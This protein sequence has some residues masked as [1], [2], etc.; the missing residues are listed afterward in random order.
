MKNEV[1]IAIPLSTDVIHSLTD[2]RAEYGLDPKRQNMGKGTFTVFFSIDGLGDDK[3]FVRLQQGGH[4]KVEAIVHDNEGPGLTPQLCI[5][6]GQWH[7]LEFDGMHF[8]GIGD[9]PA[10]RT[11]VFTLK[12]QGEVAAFFCYCYCSNPNIL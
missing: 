4:I 7:A 1:F 9:T 3:R 8:S 12:N 2:E 6:R 10:L 5:A 11:F